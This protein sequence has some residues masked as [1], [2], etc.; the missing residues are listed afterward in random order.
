MAKGV[1]KFQLLTLDGHFFARLRCL[2][3]VYSIWTLMAGIKRRLEHSRTMCK[4]A[5]KLSKTALSAVFYLAMASCL[6]VVVMMARKY[7]NFYHLRQVS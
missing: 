6:L 1:E 4:T 7:Q 5:P 2:V 3:S